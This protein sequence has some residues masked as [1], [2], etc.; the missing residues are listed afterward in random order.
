MHIQ[1]Y[2]LNNVLLYFLYYELYYLTEF[3]NK[4]YF[5]SVYGYVLGIKPWMQLKYL[6]I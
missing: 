5:S 6:N 2:T 4:V 1:E 3:P